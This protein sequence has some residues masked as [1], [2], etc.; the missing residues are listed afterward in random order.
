MRL[1]LRGN[2]HRRLGQESVEIAAAPDTPLRER[3]QWHVRL[4]D[5]SF[6]LDEEAA[7]TVVVRG[8]GTQ[9]LLEVSTDRAVARPEVELLDVATRTT[10]RRTTDELLLLLVHRG[11]ALVEQRHLL[12]EL[13]VMVLEGDDPLEL[14]VDAADSPLGLAVVRLHP[15]LD[16]PLAWV[17]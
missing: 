16:R 12:A 11:A 15:A 1:L 2:S 14:S 5:G 4:H 6:S 3:W 9:Q 17:P 8:D 13:D 10:V 7:G